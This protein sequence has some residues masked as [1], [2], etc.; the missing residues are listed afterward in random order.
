MNRIQYKNQYTREHYDRI[1]LALPKGQKDRIKDVALSLGMSVNEYMYQLVCDDLSSG[2][3]RLGQK[4]QGF[5]EEQERLLE[6]WQVGRKYFNMIEDL[7]Y[8]KEDGYFICLKKGF[9]NDV[10]GDR[11]IRCTKT[12]EVRQMISRSHAV[13]QDAEPIEGLGAEVVQQLKKWQIPRMYYEMIE[14][15]ST[16]RTEGH[17]ITLKEGYINEFVGDRV[18]HVDKANTFRNIMKYSKKE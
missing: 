14:S 7:S 5:T 6:K 4:K 13:I 12:K 17:T 8:S 11:F 3:S 2:A 10:S 1:T 15:I 9:I 16:S 18:I